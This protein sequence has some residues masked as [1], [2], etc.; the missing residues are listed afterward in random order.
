M[1]KIPLFLLFLLLTITL[2][3][4]C[5]DQETY[6]IRVEQDAVFVENKKIANTVDI[7]KQDSFLVEPLQKAL[8]SRKDTSKNCQIKIDP[9]QSYDVLYKIANTCNTAGY[10]NLSIAS[11]TNGE[12][13]V[14]PFFLECPETNWRCRTEEKTEESSRYCYYCIHFAMDID[15]DTLYAISRGSYI[16]KMFYK[17]NLDSAI[18]ELAERVIPLVDSFN[19]DFVYIYGDNDDTKISNIIPVMHKLRTS[20]FTK[21][22]LRPVYKPPKPRDWSKY[23]L[24]GGTFTDARDGKKYKTIKI[25][26][27][28]GWQRI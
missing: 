15:G 21:M 17:E 19:R 10:T 26:F 9:E 2:I 16:F 23:H 14:L 5:T 28:H 12:N 8:E 11:K 27:K 6:L 4:G 18:A 7:A 3:L 1:G 24:R 13:E 20:G 22:N 25:V